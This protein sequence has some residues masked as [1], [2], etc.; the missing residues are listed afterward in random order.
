MTTAQVIHIGPVSLT[1]YRIV[2]AAGLLRVLLKRET[3]PG[4]VNTIDKLMVVW[5][6][7]LVFASLFH[8]W[9]QGSGPI[10]T[11][12]LIFN[13][14]CVYFLIRIWCRDLEDLTTMLRITAWLLV[15]VAIAMVAEHLVEKNAFAV[16]GGVPESVPI[17]DGKIRAQGPFQHP[18]L[19]GIVGAVCVP[20]M[21]GIWRKYRASSAAGLAAS[22][23]MILASTSSTPLM[24][25][26][27]G[28]GATIVWHFRSWIRLVRWAVIGAYLSAGGS[29][30]PPG[31]FF[32]VE[33]RLHR[34][35][36]RLVSIEIDS[37]VDPAF[38]GVVGLW[39]RRY[40]CLDVSQHRREAL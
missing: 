1:V 23:T 16:F 4:G 2:L 30:E 18:I 33:D 25:L 10:Y 6:A 31:V 35:Q 5:S 40:R 37:V 27:L 11:S 32:D 19:A 8:Q 38:I 28:I 17:R 34:K 39:D 22:I 9:M 21:L 15:P 3:L 29:N 24:S 20:L 36:H 13:I 12:G 7:W 26:F 14:I